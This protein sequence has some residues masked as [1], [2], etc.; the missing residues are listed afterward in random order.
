MMAGKARHFQDSAME[1][2]IMQAT[3]PAKCKAYGRRVHNFTEESW[4]AV[5]LQIVTQGNFYKFSQTS[6]LRR[7]MLKTGNRT[8]VEAAPNDCIWGIGI[9]KEQASSGMA[10]RG[11]NLLGE[12]LMAARK[13]IKVEVV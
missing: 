4:A 13:Q 7:A 12:A 1:I 6:S 8:L 2:K 3:T 10:W 9:S 11:L 5:R